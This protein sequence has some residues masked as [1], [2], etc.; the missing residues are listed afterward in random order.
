MGGRPCLDDE[1]S[2]AVD[3][4]IVRRGSSPEALK[5]EQ[6]TVK[7]TYRWADSP[8]DPIYN[9]KFVISSPK[10]GPQSRRL[11]KSSPTDTDGPKEPISDTADR[12]LDLQ[13]LPFDPALEFR[14]AVEAAEK[15]RKKE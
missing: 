11:K 10:S 1:S 12:V 9:G 14:K 4:Q 15:K 13:N 3:I 5:E 2:T 8:D 7:V 6:K